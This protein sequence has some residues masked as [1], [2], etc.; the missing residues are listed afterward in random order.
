MFRNAGI[1]Y[2]AF[3]LFLKPPT[4]DVKE[5]PREVLIARGSVQTQSMGVKEQKDKTEEA[6][7]ENRF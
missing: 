3:S 2:S 7:L 4:A 6:K 1:D 5:D